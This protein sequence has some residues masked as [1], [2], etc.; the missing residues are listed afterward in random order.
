MALSR[1]IARR[2]AATYS[3]IAVRLLTALMFA[4]A[5]AGCKSAGSRDEANQSLLAGVKQGELSAARAALEKGADKEAKNES[6]R[7]PLMLASLKGQEEM[8]KF[9]LE[10]GADVNAKDPEGMTPLLWA[11][12]GGNVKVVEALLFKGADV[13][14]RD[15]NK[16]GALD[17]ARDNAE[18]AKAL[19]RA[20]AK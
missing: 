9:L 3:Q 11:A 13:H 1:K 5:C 8:V 17:W 19:K 4:F 10:R 16:Q 12:F 14:A 18:V 15:A 20:G 6:G 2:K 7:T